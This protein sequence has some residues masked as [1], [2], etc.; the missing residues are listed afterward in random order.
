MAKVKAKCPTVW[1]RFDAQGYE[2]LVDGQ[3]V[4]EAGNSQR[5]STAI[6][7]DALYAVPVK[8]LARYA[9]RTGKEIAQEIG[10]KWIGIEPR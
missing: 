9:S 4:Y 2:V 7:T 10:G 5:D 8:T 3:P 6:E 1:A